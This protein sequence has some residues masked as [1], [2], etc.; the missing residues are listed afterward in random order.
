MEIVI[1]ALESQVL[2][3][4]SLAKLAEEIF[5]RIQTT[6]LAIFLSEQVAYRIDPEFAAGLVINRWPDSTTAPAGIVELLVDWR[7]Q[8]RKL[9]PYLERLLSDAVTHADWR[10]AEELMRLAREIFPDRA[11][12]TRCYIKGGSA[13]IDCEVT[14]YAAKGFGFLSEVVATA[15]SAGDIDTAVRYVN[16][17]LGYAIVEG[18]PALRIQAEE[19]LALV[20]EAANGSR[21]LREWLAF[22]EDRIVRNLKERMRGK[23]LH[24]VGDREKPWK[25]EIEISLGLKELRWHEAEKNGGVNHDWENSLDPIRDVVVVLWEQI[26][27]DTVGP[28]KARCDRLGVLQIESRTSKRDLLAELNRYLAGNER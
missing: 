11:S 21:D 23:I 17:L 4:E 22:Q 27:H 14:E 13:L 7:S 5:P 20:E 18:D 9:T 26:G 16:T 12:W 6:A 24:L 19:Q 28:L 8:K 2:G 25:S 15:V 10:R 1:R 3:D